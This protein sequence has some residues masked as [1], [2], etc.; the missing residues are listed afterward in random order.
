MVKTITIDKKEYVIDEKN[1]KLIEI[2]DSLQFTTARLEELLNVQ[3]IFHLQKRSL[4][5]KLQKS[6]ISSKAGVI[7]DDH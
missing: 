1:E 7:L 2:F 4:M 5:E 6:I 3:N